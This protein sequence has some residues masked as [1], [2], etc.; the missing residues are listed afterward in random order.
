MSL[1]LACQSEAGLFWSSMFSFQKLSQNSGWY[2]ILAQLSYQTLLL[3][4]LCHCW[5]N[6]IKTPSNSFM[7]ETRLRCLR[8]SCLL[9][10][11]KNGR[12]TV[13]GLKKLDSRFLDRKVLSRSQKTPGASTTG[14]RPAGWSCIE[15]PALKSEATGVKNSRDQPG[16][17][18]QGIKIH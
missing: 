2:H 17:C 4:Y 10:V 13:L 9:T 8:I 18:N 16:H 6:I 3:Y 5:W 7:R 14:Q 1:L 11:E 15:G 12:K